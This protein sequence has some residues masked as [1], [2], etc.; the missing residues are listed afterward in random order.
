MDKKR[1]STGDTSLHIAVQEQ[2]KD[3]VL[4]LLN[5]T[6]ARIDSVNFKNQTPLQQARILAETSSDPDAQ[7]IYKIMNDYVSI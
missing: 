3:T 7:E 6:K 5:N 4:Y 2:C 1:P